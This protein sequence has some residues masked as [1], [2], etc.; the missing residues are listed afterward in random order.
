VLA[1]FPRGRVL[2]GQYEACRAN[3]AAELARTFAFLGL[4]PFDPGSAAYRSEH[5]PTTSRKFEPSAGLR[6]AL[7]DGWAADLEQLP[8][9][10]PG[11]DLSLWP[12]AREVGLV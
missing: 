1:A 5:N 7:L 6:S 10:V 12:S 3:P 9:L 4:T 2:V 8:G 11:L